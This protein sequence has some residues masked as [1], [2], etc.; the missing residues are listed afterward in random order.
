MG[1]IGFGAGIASPSRDLLVRAASPKN[2][3]GR[4]YGVVYSGM[5][6]GQAIG[7]VLFGTLMDAQHAAWVFAGIGLF[8]ILAVFTA[9]GVDSKP[10]SGRT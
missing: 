3:T 5:D 9:T 2:A 6:C 4:V 1:L 7:P 8:Q 10:L